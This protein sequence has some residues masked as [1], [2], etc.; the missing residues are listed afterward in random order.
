MFGLLWDGKFGNVFGG[1]LFYKGGIG[2]SKSGVILVTLAYFS[3]FMFGML[4]IY[5]SS[6]DDVNRVAIGQF[7]VTFAKYPIQGISEFNETGGIKEKIISL[8]NTTI[9]LAQNPRGWA[10]YSP[11]AYVGEVLDTTIGKAANVSSMQIGDSAGAIGSKDKQNHTVRVASFML[12][13]KL[14][15]LVT[16][17]NSTIFDEVVEDISVQ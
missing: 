6:G 13:A 9:C 4:V 8:P 7:T 12:T 1:W 2:I 14:K 10:A 3:V 11:A 17:T 16:G 5:F 15:C